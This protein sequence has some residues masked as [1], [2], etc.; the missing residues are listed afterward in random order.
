[1]ERV[2]VIPA[3]LEDEIKSLQQEQKDFDLK[4]RIKYI[5][6][7][8]LYVNLAGL[9]LKSVPASILEIDI[10]LL[11]LSLNFLV[12]LP[13]L[14][15]LENL[16]S[17]S[18]RFNKFSKFPETLFGNNLL[19]I[20]LESNELTS[21][22]DRFGELSDMLY[23]DLGFNRI[24]ELPLS[25]AKM[26]DL[27]KLDLQYNHFK[28]FPEI[29]TK[30]LRLRVID[31]SSNRLK[32][33][34]PQLS[35]LRKVRY[36]DLSNNQIAEVPLALNRFTEMTFFDISQ[37]EGVIIPDNLASTYENRFLFDSKGEYTEVQLT[38]TRDD[39]AVDMRLF[40]QV[41]ERRK[42]KSVD[43][44]SHFNL[45]SLFGKEEFSPEVDE[46]EGESKD[47]HLEK[48]ILQVDY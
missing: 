23:L 32:N 21:F 22:P 42:N 29:I 4:G 41:Q 26:C 44:D 40:N 3:G 38:R 30:L 1:M 36:L 35:D 46:I 25:F 18:L 33:V 27:M 19:K 31:L 8:Q 13:D 47:D 39:S 5:R 24:S 14:S 20:N 45:E 2:N 12:D 15:S 10:H 37:N 16:I 48:K 11:D 43:W 6:D 9:S 17:I 28:T 34:S 7:S